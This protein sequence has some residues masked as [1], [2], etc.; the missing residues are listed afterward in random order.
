MDEIT[1]VSIL[2]FISL[3]S[4]LLSLYFFKKSSNSLQSFLNLQTNIMVVA[5]INKTLYLNRVGL[6]FFGCRNTQEFQKKF[7]NINNL[8]IEEDGCLNKYS[9]GKNWLESIYKSKNK[10]EKIKLKTP[11]DNNMEYYFYIQV[12]KIGRDRYILSL[13]DITRL[14]RDKDMI[15]QLADYD[16][17]TNI[18][19]R[20]KFNEIFPLYINRALSYNERLSIILFDIDHFKSINDNYGHNV[21]DRVLIELASVVK[22]ILKDMDIRKSTVFSRWGGEEFV[23][24][25]QFKTVE[26]T[27]KVANIIRK[28][29]YNYS[30]NIVK[31]VT[32]SFGVTQF[33][34]DDKEVDIFHRVDK[35]LY[36]A[37]ERGRNRV[38]VK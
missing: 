4:T 38:V 34:P 3:S 12:S 7:N 35:A 26:E 37:K 19:S 31:K 11:I 1:L 5:T 29:I 36:E 25:V 8:F 2:I 9:S 24:L 18:Y 27:A 33:K 30:F 28:G 13:T 23:I 20:V 32:C 21:G 10:R 22:S 16:T 14:E 17:L 6:S 15:R